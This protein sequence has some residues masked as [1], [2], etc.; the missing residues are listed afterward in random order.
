MKMNKS[1]LFASVAVCGLALSSCGGSG[2]E[3]EYFAF[4]EKEGGRWGLMNADGD[5]LLEDYDDNKPSIVTEGR[6]FL[7]NSNGKYELYSAEEKPEQIGSDV[8]ADWAIFT[9]GLAPVAKDSSSIIYINAD[10]EVKIELDKEIETATCF[11]DGLA[12]VEIDGKWGFINKD[13][14]VVIPAIYASVGGFKD[15]LAIVED[16][17]VYKKDS[18]EREPQTWNVINKDGER[19]FEKD[20]LATEY[21]AEW[22]SYVDGVLAVKDVEK[23]RI[24]FIDEAG[25]IVGEPLKETV[26]RIGT[27]YD[28]KF[29]FVESDGKYGFMN[30]DGEVLVKAKYDIMAYN[31]NI[32]IVKDGDECFVIDEEGEKVGEEEYDDMNLFPEFVVG[33]EDKIMV[34]D[35]KMWQIADAE[36]NVDK[37]A[38]EYYS[39]SFN[40]STSASNQIRPSLW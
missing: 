18:Y 14:E 25:E 38:P 22:P 30:T 15:G 32:L 40:V 7:R 19:Q 3:S 10:G 29:V 39:I 12:A 1:L 33:G 31:G 20:K 4:Q 5:V 9:E 13:G 36:G 2:V 8:Y 21:T 26:A 27:A 6:F 11:S 24:C 16:T 23:K 37:D 17:I 35:G 28:G 34:K